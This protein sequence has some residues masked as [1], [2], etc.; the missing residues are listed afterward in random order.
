MACII[1]KIHKF[2]NHTKIWY[3]KINYVFTF[4]SMSEMIFFT[5]NDLTVILGMTTRRCGGGFK[6][7]KPTSPL[8]TILTSPPPPDGG[9]K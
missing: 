4:F 9:N 3:F 1:N 2:L 7:Y 5:S 6:N 8:Y